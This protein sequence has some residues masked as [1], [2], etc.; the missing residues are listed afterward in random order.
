VTDGRATPFAG[1][2]GRLGWGLADQGLSSLTNFVLGVLVARTV[3][4]TQFGAFS[5]AFAAYLIVASLSRAVN[6]QPLL[7][8]YSG[9]PAPD[10]RRGASAG[11]GTAL[12]I[13]IAAAILALG[14]AVA[15]GG[16][17]R[18]A[19]LALALV[20]PGLIVQDAWRFAF[21][22]DGRGRSAFYNDLVWA[23]TQ[24]AALSIAINIG[25]GTVF[26]A[27]IAW[28][29]AATLA[30]LIA[31]A[32]ARLIPRPLAAH[33][34]WDE[35]RDLIP[36]YIGEALA[37]I[38]AGQLL[39]YAVGMVTGLAVVGALRGAQILLGPLYVVVQGAYLVAVPE[40]VRVLRSSPP[41]FARLCLAAGLSLAGAAI[42][43]TA[44]LVLLPES[45]G[46]LLMGTVWDPARAVLLAWGLSFAASNL[47]S[48]AAIGLRAMAAAP[49]TLRAAVI[50][51][52]FV[53]VGAVAGAA[54]AGLEGTA[55]G[56]LFTQVIGI[57]VWWWEFRGGYRDH[58]NS[59]AGGPRTAP[60][61]DPFRPGPM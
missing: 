7:I 25:A 20:F 9:V 23:G 26:W 10:W 22:A 15:S 35:H 32:Q 34:W 39:L 53:F 12:L 1:I 40:A 52:I 49:R 42:A 19:F 54:V 41:R 8:R 55:W 44:V 6:A 5:L 59:E 31:A 38:M 3:G 48:G 60:S 16:S 43:W 18:S 61:R 29:G 56:V 57:G 37:N 17:L 33:D 58:I 46:H 14:I 2:A 4:L 27:V 30:A 13:G 51:S 45:F 47:G 11:T 28:G 36:P 24:L 50:A 21:F